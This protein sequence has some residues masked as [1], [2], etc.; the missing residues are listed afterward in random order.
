[1]K[2][3]I[4]KYMVPVV[5]TTELINNF[6]P[7]TG[8]IRIT[9]EG[10]TEQSYYESGSFEKGYGRLIKLKVMKPNIVDKSFWIKINHPEIPAKKACLITFNESK[11][12][13]K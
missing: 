7:I 11:W 2:S 5:F 9:E 4:Q 6:C 3:K 12:W 10:K 1:M 8:G 13:W